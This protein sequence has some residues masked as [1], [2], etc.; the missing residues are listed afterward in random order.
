MEVSQSCVSFGGCFPG[1][2]G[3][4]CCCFALT[5][6]SCLAHVNRGYVYE[7]GPIDV[8]RFFKIVNL[9]RQ[10]EKLQPEITAQLRSEFRILAMPEAPGIPAGRQCSDPFTREFF[11]RCN[12][13]VPDDHILRLPRIHA[14]TVAKL[15][16]LGV[17][18]IHDIPESY[19]ITERLRRA[20]TSVQMRKPWY[21]PELRE[22]FGRLKYPLYFADFETV[23][24]ALPRFA[25]MGPYD[26]SEGFHLKKF[27]RCSE[28]PSAADVYNLAGHILSFVRHKERYG[29]GHIFDRRRATNRK[30]RI[31]NTTR[32]T[33]RQFFF[34][35]A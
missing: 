1:T 15:A 31:A 27:T 16:A 3:G 18:S 10:V 13:P 7:G 5:A 33:Q 32:F 14:N 30:S 20:C 9:T 8:H 22:E 17:Q 6:T 2:V 28:H 29:I 34:V 24:P 21:G 35:Y 4:L 19:P 12:E 26:Q 25:K 23:N 11:D